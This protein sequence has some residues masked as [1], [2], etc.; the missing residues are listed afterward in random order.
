MV[1]LNFTQ[2][3]TICQ[4]IYSIRVCC[5]EIL[6]GMCAVH[7]ATMSL[8]RTTRNTEIA[9]TLRCFVV[10]PEQTLKLRQL[11]GGNFCKYLDKVM[12]L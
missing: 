3:D 8:L 7:N 2:D 5:P 9:D 6:V 4:G 10:H 11:N 1:I 12:T